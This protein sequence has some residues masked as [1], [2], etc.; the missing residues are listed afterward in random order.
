MYLFTLV[1][2]VV[3]ILALR[4]LCVAVEGLSLAVRGYVPSIDPYVPSSGGG[5]SADGDDSCGDVGP[6]DRC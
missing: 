1:F 6:C 3:Q 5:R 2:Y 4:R